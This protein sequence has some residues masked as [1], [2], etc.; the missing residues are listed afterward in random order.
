[1]RGFNEWQQER[2]LCP[3]CGKDM[4]KW[5]L[6]THLQTQNGVAKGGLVSEVDKV[7]GGDGPRTYRLGFPAR[8]GPRPCPVEG[9][10]GRVLTRT[11]IRVKF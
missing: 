8:S 11:E 9:W 4:S 3:E 6:V 10:S 5:S 7:D 1:M 2:V